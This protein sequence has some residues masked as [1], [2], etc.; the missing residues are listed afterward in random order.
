M[1]DRADDILARVQKMIF[2][3]THGKD[4]PSAVVL[5][6]RD[7]DA[8]FHGMR[9]KAPGGVFT[10]PHEPRQNFVIAGIPIVAGDANSV[11]TN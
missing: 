5:S 11:E 4:R 1:T 2:A 10:A 9:E 7:W 3:H 8:L 6:A